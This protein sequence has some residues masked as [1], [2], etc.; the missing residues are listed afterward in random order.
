M[1][2]GTVRCASHAGGASTSVR[3]RPG[4]GAAGVGGIC[5]GADA[6]ASASSCHVTAIR[7][8]REGCRK[9]ALGKMGHVPISCYV[10]GRAQPHDAD[11]LMWRQDHETGQRHHCTARKNIIREGAQRAQQWAHHVASP[12][13]A[14]G[15]REVP[16][17]APRG[18]LRRG[19]VEKRRRRPAPR[20]RGAVQRRLPDLV[21]QLHCLRGAPP[22]T[23]CTGH[24]V[25]CVASRDDGQS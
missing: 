9:A 22:R 18:G 6:S 16:A 12:C 19:V 5:G 24:C 11:R 23:T 8:C 10:E 25:V 21:A 13:G 7:G 4:S 15:W 3:A 14:G 2:S 1:G 17:V 20:Q